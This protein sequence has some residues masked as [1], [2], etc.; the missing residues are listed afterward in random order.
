MFKNPRIR[1]YCVLDDDD[2]LYV[3]NG[4]SDLDK[5]RDHLIVTKDCN[6]IDPKDEGIMPY[7]KEMIREILKKDNCVRRLALRRNK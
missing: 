3:R 6:E 5:V 7:H 1:S 4:I 2:M